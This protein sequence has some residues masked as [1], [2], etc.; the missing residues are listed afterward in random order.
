MDRNQKNPAMQRE[1]KHGGHEIYRHNQVQPSDP[2][3][4][5]VAMGFDGANETDDHHEKNRWKNQKQLYRHLI[6]KS[7]ASSAIFAIPSP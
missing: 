2:C 7:N 4:E 3:T 6:F 5:S 1:Q